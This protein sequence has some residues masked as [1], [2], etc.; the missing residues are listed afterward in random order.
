[1]K[2]KEKKKGVIRGCGQQKMGAFVNLDAYSLV[3]IPAAF[4]FAFVCHLGGMGLWFG[5]LCCLVVQML[6]LLTI[7]LCGTNWDKEALKAK[8]RVFSS[9]LSADMTTT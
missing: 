4:F 1:M 6:L 8:D 7:S 9:S 5:I 2:I 3:G